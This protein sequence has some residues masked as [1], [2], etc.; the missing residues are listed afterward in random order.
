[1]KKHLAIVST[2]GAGKSTA[3]KYLESRGFAYFKLSQI[4]SDEASK[5]GLD[6]KDR[7]VLRSIGNELRSKYGPAFLAKMAIRKLTESN[8]EKF[9][10]E[11]IR[12]PAELHEF[13][14]VFG[15]DLLIL[16][17]DAS[18]ESRYKR[19]LNRC[20]KNEKISFD[21]FKRSDE[22]DLGKDSDKNGQQNQKC[23]DMAEVTVNN[24]STLDEFYSKLNEIFNKYFTQ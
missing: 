13:K 6:P 18:I 4:L 15:D 24:D 21:D 7:S 11:S 2:I 8:I 17:V 22:L 19:V 16:R 1:M 10:F 5:R 23:L 3:G 9:C 20:E 14:R 12:N